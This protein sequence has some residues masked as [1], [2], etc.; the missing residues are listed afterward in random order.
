MMH[1]GV[2]WNTSDSMI[3]YSFWS[4]LKTN[5]GVRKTITFADRHGMEDTLE[6]IAETLNITR[7]RVRQIK[8]KAIKKLQHDS[9]NRLLIDYLG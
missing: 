2:S 1:D 6:Q 7:E 5:Q 3:V 4:S 8:E 9:R